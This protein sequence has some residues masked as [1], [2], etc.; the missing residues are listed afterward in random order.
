MVLLPD[1]EFKDLAAMESNLKIGIL[2]VAAN[3]MLYYIE[4]E[5]AKEGQIIPTFN[6]SMYPIRKD[7]GTLSTQYKAG[8]NAYEVVYVDFNGQLKHLWR[9]PST[10]MWFEQAIYVPMTGRICQ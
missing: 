8:I 6:T 3:G 10:K 9:D 5:R 4:G 7:V 2:A 1:I